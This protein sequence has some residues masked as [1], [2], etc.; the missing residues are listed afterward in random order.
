M[1]DYCKGC[2][3]DV[4]MRTGPKACPFNYLY[5]D[6]LMRNRQKL[7][8]NQRLRQV[9]GAVDAMS[10]AKR[11]EIRASAARLL[12]SLKSSYGGREAA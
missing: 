12:A 9:Y 1:S 8:R 4:K 11:A 5:W 2:A 10:D 6:F 7:G 3:Y